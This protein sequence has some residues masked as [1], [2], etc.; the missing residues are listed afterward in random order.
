MRLLIV[1]PN[2]S[3]DV[4]KMIEDAAAGQGAEGT[5]IS[6]LTAPMAYRISRLVPKPRSPATLFSTC[7]PNTMVSTTQPSSPPSAIRV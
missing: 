4:T 2:T 7:W 1:N 6:V 3:A 5:E